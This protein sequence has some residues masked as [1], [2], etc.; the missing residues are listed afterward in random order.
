MV[1]KPFDQAAPIIHTLNKSGYECFFVGGSVRDYQLDRPIGDIDLATDADPYTVQQLFNR[2]VPVGIDHGT[3]LVLLN[4]ESYEVTTYRTEGEYKDHRRPDRVFFVDSIEEDLSRRDFTINAMAMG[5]DGNIIDP[6]NGQ[7]DLKLKRIQTVRHAQDRFNEDALRMLRAV[8]FSS[9]L[10]F[11]IDDEVVMA[12]KENRSLLDA[13]SVERIT[14]ELTKMFGGI[15]V[16][17]AL[18]YLKE[19]KLYQQLPVFQEHENVFLEI[20]EQLREPIDNQAV[21]IAYLHFIEPSIAISAWCNA[22]K[23]SNAV[24]RKATIIHEAFAQHQ[25]K[26][27]TNNLLYKLTDEHIASWNDFIHLVEGKSYDV[28]ELYSMFEQLPIKQKSDL[29][30]NGS[31]LIRICPERKK[32]RWISEYLSEL[33]YQVLRGKLPNQKD[34]IE[35]QVKAWNQTEQD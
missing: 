2:T 28:S 22:Y 29:A 15:G 32:G 18:E 8:R 34:E 10:D 1:G 4:N 11:F 23:L 35:R 24:K 20:Y 19:T 26:G 7:Q 6:F 3:I 13:I 5:L 16:G 17:K 9:Q 30:I 21:L 12:I 33:E 25:T 14:V 27:L 31:D